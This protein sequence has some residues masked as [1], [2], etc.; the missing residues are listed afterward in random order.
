MT[1]TIK[2][3][4]V[5]GDGISDG[6]DG[7]I[8]IPFTMPGEV[9]DGEVVGNRLPRPKILEPSSDRVKAPCSHF[10]SCG[11]CALQQASDQFLAEWKA[12]VVRNALTAQGLD[13]TIRPTITSPANTPRRATFAASRTKKGVLIGFH[14]RASGT[15]VEIPNCKLLHPDIMA[16]MPAMEALTKIGASRKAV[17][18]IAITQSDAGADISIMDAK[19]AGGPLLSE[20]GSLVEKFTLARLSWNG[21]PVATR[22]PPVQNF[23][24]I[25]I[26]PPPGAFLQ[27]TETGQVAL[28]EAVKLAVGTAKHVLDLFAGCGTFSLPLARQSQVLAMEGEADLLS[29]LDLSWRN[30]TGLKTV[31]TEKR[32]LFRNP[33]IVEDLKH[34]DAVV[35]DP[36]RAG[37]KSQCEEM[38]KSGVPVIAF[39]S[40]NPVTFA[41][42]A[43]ILAGGGYNIEWIQVVDQFRWSSHVE[44]VARF[45]KVQ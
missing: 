12:E 42:D 22:V 35:I 2:H 3:L 34:F 14:G 19:E 23:D 31:Q 25:Q 20:L 1:F 45:S 18:S 39:V 26:T 13:C 5:Q 7:P 27:A 17:I 32:D 28:T 8:Y 10:K 33:V 36:P 16:A 15:V 6:P 4:S 11:G 30:A 29:A 24:G 40:C 38:A 9:V 41:R 37:A 43:K 21:E 44:L